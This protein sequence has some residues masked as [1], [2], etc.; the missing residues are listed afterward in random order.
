MCNR[1][2]R[3]GGQATYG[4]TMSAISPLVFTTSI[5][6]MAIASMIAALTWSLRSTPSLSEIIQDARR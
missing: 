6:V 4:L 1:E 2:Q 5:L 3:H